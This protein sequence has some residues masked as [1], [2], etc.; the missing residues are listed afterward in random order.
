MHALWLVLSCDLL[1][2]RRVDDVIKKKNKKK[3][4]TFFYSLS[5][6]TNRF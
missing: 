3:I 2:D 1:E 5:Y 4:K 6:K